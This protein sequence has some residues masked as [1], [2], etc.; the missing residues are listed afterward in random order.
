M[1]D[2]GIVKEII[3]KDLLLYMLYEVRICVCI[4]KGC[5]IGE[6]NYVCIFEV[7]LEG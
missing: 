4:F 7:L 6:V 3:L 2:V 5:S 1:N